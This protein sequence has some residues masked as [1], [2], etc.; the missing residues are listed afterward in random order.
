[1][2]KPRAELNVLIVEDE[3]FVGLLLQNQ[4]QDAGFRRMVLENCVSDAMRSIKASLP[5]LCFL[6]ISLSG[7]MSYPIAAHLRAND[8]RFS[9]VTG[10][11]DNAIETEW[12]EHP[13]LEKP[14]PDDDLREMLARL[15]V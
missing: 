4:L 9:F 10:F 11:A 8:V 2:S 3:Y 13:R 7:E 12:R 1:V 6:D 5:D 14:C 15:G